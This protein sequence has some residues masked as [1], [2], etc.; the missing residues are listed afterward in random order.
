M[1]GY[2]NNLTIEKSLVDTPYING[3]TYKSLHKE[4]AI[5]NDINRNYS[6]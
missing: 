2:K 1:K 5:L 4:K 3:A 6:T